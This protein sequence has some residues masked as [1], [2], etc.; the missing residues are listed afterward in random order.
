MSSKRSTKPRVAVHAEAQRELREARDFYDR[1]T[2]GMGLV[3]VE[4]VER[5]LGLLQEFPRIGKEHVRGTRRRT[6]SRAWPYSIVYR[7]VPGGI[8]VIALAH[9]SRRPDYWTDRTRRR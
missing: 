5:E 7:A 1:E 6:M 9:H 2:P 4:A 8:H 3:F